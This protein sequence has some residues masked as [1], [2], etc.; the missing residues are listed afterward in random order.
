M[1]EIDPRLVRLVARHF[2]DLQGLQNGDLGDHAVDRRLGVVT[3]SS[4]ALAF[5]D[6]HSVLD[7]RSVS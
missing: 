2:N 1:N 4:E 5:V 7:C 6:G 3:T